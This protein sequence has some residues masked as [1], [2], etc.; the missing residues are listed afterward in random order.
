MVFMIIFVNN[1]V[2]NV[3][4]SYR[5]LK[6]NTYMKYYDHFHDNTN[7]GDTTVEPNIKGNY[8]TQENNFT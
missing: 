1:D 7:R 3:N 6:T 8:R 2:L 4:L 5:S